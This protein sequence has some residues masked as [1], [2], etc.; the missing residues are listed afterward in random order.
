MIINT[1]NHLSSTVFGIIIV[2]A[3]SAVILLILWVV[4]TRWGSCNQ[5]RE[6]S[7]QDGVQQLLLQHHLQSIEKYLDLFII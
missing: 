6:N 5:H 1:N 7:L 3:I 4:L 2:R